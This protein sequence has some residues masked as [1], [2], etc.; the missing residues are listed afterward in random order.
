MAGRGAEKVASKI[1]KVVD[2]E[3]GE[4][5]EVATVA[6]IG[7]MKGPAKKA[8]IV[9]AVGF[10]ASLATGRGSFGLARRVRMGVVL[11][12]RRLLFVEMHRTGKYLRTASEVPRATLARGPV[13]SR[14]YLF[15]D[16]F[17]RDSGEPIVKLS[18]PIPAKPTGQQIAD[19]LPERPPAEPPPAGT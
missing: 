12:D 2:L 7:S 13:Q 10:V 11:T 18:F 5:V 19:A 8:A 1:L 17:D 14:M 3:E 6:E 16:L 9:S 15:Y 4:I